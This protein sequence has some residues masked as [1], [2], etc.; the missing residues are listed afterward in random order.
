MLIKDLELY[1]INIGKHYRVPSIDDYKQEV[2]L[3]LF[4]KG[5]DFILELQS[6][7]KLKNY[8]YRV[9]VLLLYSKQGAYYKKYI[10][11]IILKSELTGIEKINNK[12]FNEERI[13]DLLK[14]LNGMD[15]KLLEQLILF[16]GNKYSF[17]KKS[18]ISYST[19]NMMINNLAEKIK[20]NWSINDFYD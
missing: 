3:I 4:E 15:K 6:E 10:E 7:N 5:E 20:K 18:N 16:R 11:P 12:N 1:I 13:Q 9:C 2:F 14:S 17:S 8:V 19:I